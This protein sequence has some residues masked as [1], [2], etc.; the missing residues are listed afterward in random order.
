MSVCFFIFRP[1]P[2][3]WICGLPRRYFQSPPR[4]H[5]RFFASRWFRVLYYFLAPDLG[6]CRGH[7]GNGVWESRIVLLRYTTGVFNECPDYHYKWNFNTYLFCFPYLFWFPYHFSPPNLFVSLIFFVS[8]IIFKT[9]K[10][11]V[12]K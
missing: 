6:R 5:S 4:S 3:D 1:L 8:L 12:L 11:N 7:S 2:D 10:K 9:W